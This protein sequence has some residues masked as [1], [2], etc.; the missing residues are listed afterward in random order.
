[1]VVSPDRQPLRSAWLNPPN[2]A[3]R[4]RFSRSLRAILCAFGSKEGFPGD[5]T[6]FPGSPGPCNLSSAQPEGYE[7]FNPGSFRAL[8]AVQGL[9]P[10]RQASAVPRLPRQLLPASSHDP[11]NWADLVVA[12]VGSASP[13]FPVVPPFHCPVGVVRLVYIPH[14]IFPSP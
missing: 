12:L 13:A 1:M 11:L 4:I 9:R 7:V 6:G 10:P 8:G 2:V 5:L 3:Q 14:A